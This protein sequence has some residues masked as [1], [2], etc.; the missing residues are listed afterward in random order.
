LDIR[1]RMKSLQNFGVLWFCEKEC[2]C[3]DH[4]YAQFQG[5]AVSLQATSGG[6]SQDTMTWLVNL[7]SNTDYAANGPAILGGPFLDSSWGSPDAIE[8]TLEY[9]SKHPWIRIIDRNTEFHKEC[10]YSSDEAVNT[11]SSSIPVKNNTPILSELT[12]KK[13][14]YQIIQ[15]YNSIP[16][17]QLT[18]LAWSMITTLTQQN[19]TELRALSVNY[20]GQTGHILA[21]ARWTNSP[22]SIADCSLDL[23]WDGE[24]ECVLS[25]NNIFTTY[26]ISGGYLAFAFVLTNGEIH[27]VI[28]PTHQLSLGLSEPST[29]NIQNGLYADAGQILGALA[30]SPAQWSSYQYNISPDHLV[31]T[32]TD[33]ATRK[34]FTITDSV[35]SLQVD[36]MDSR[37]NYQIPFVIDPWLMYEPDWAKLYSIMDHNNYSLLSIEGLLS[38][39]VSSTTQLSIASF[40]TPRNASAL[41][42]SPDYDY[43]RGYF[44]P[45]PT[46]VFEANA[47][48]KFTVDVQILP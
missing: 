25:N 42:E 33:M 14:G 36:R 2:M 35:I 40:L 37:R 6:L 10:E 27:E 30:D 44:L 45:F 43:S 26:E 19:S 3:L 9:I 24:P 16:T 17:N 18:K 8:P 31:M 34:T 32:S 15:A 48:D 46:T 22:T 41:P 4:D 28:G 7:A 38:I 1:F 12:E 21:A 13:M 23:D 29:W 20:L 47:S 5:N 11:S 39:R